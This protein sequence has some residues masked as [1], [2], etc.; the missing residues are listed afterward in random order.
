M[1]VA[2]GAILAAA[3]VEYRREGSLGAV[4]GGIYLDSTLRRIDRGDAASGEVVVGPATRDH[5][6][7]CGCAVVVPLGAA[8]LKGKRDPVP[9]YRLES[10]AS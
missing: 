9:I 1:A 8:E 6:R 4:F 10:I 7:A 2:F 5:L 3:R